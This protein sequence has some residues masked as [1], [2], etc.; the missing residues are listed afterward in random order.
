MSKIIFCNNSLQGLILFR[1]DVFESYAEEGVSVIL[2][3]HKDCAFNYNN[4]LIRFIPIKIE[5]SSRN[6]LKDMRLFISLFKIYKKENPDFIFNYTIKPNIYGSIAAKL[7]NIPSCAMIAGLGYAFDGNGFTKRIMRMC[8][9]FSL[10]FPKKV[11][12]LNTG[13][14]DY[15]IFHKYIK[16]EQLVLLKGGEG[17]NIDQY[18]P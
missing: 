1:K 6:I 8:Y 9:R 18:R 16:K 7:C 13:N 11:I 14:R 17:V 12:V 10:R 3:A 5:S 15:L 4:P 2:V